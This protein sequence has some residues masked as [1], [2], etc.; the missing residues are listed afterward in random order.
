MQFHHFQNYT[1]IN[2]YSCMAFKFEYKEM[3]PI[4]VF[5]QCCWSLQSGKAWQACAQQTERSHSHTSSAVSRQVYPQALLVLHLQSVFFQQMD[6]YG[7]TSETAWM[8]R[9]QKNWLKYTD[10]TE[11]KKITKRIYSNCSIDSSLFLQVLQISLL[12]VFFH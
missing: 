9:R 3:Y 2:C 12:L 11:L 4:F 10:F 1:I 8:Q 6:W 5:A 7:P